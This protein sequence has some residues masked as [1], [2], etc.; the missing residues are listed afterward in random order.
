MKLSSD[1]YKP[2][3]ARMSDYF[4]TIFNLRN[5]IRKAKHCDI[6]LPYWVEYPYRQEKER[7]MQNGGWHYGMRTI[8]EKH[9]GVETQFV[10]LFTWR[11]NFEWHEWK[12][13]TMR[14]LLFSPLPTHCSGFDWSGWN[15]VETTVLASM[16]DFGDARGS[17]EIRSEEM[18]RTRE[19]A[20]KTIIMLAE[21]AED[22]CTY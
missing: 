15:G 8:L 11:M 19:E 13:N 14:D 20:R 18:L 21:V 4:E 6:F 7:W 5:V 9:W 1:R 17:Y 2:E 3:K 22:Q 16:K 10:S 12:S